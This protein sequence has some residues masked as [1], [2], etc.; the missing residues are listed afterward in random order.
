MYWKELIRWLPSGYCQTRT[1]T[2]NYEN[3]LN[4]VHQR[5]NHKLNEWGGKDNDE[6]ENF[7]SWATSLPYIREF[8]FVLGERYE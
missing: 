4:M 5:K 1:V 2:M 7:I 8:L 3:I 6:L